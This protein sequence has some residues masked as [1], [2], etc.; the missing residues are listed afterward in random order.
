MNIFVTSLCLILIGIAMIHPILFM[1]VDKHVQQGQARRK[2]LQVN[3][4]VH[5]IAAAISVLLFW[6][7]SINYPLQISG[8]VY[9]VVIIVVVL[10]YWNSELTKW[11]LFTASFLFGFIVYF[12][13]INEI[14]EITPIWP[15]ILT[16]LLGSGALC[17]LIVLL[18]EEALSNRDRA[19]KSIS[20]GLIKFLVILI[21]AR[22]VWDIALLFNLSVATRYGETIS[23]M[24]FFWQVDSIRLTLLLILSIFIPLLFLL[25]FRDIITES[26]TTTKRISITVL[27]LSIFTA[28]LLSKHFLLQF[29]IVL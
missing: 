10:F 5:I 12:R 29:G 2:F 3:Y 13:T 7:Y 25:L 23:A 4:L 18:V 8:V 28:E 21:G 9:L 1:L 20:A 6:I 22:I 24:K 14:V 27:F 16:G 17:V 15:G 11:N 19:S 26:N